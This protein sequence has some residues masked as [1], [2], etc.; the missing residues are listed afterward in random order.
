[1]ER[2]AAAP[3]TQSA[4]NRLAILARVARFAGGIASL[5]IGGGKA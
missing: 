1:M 5:P 2:D 4:K 3:A